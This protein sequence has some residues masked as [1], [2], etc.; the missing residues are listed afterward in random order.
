MLYKN[1]NKFNTTTSELQLAQ[2]ISWV[3]VSSMKIRPPS[4]KSTVISQLRPMSNRRMTRDQKQSLVTQIVFK[5][6]KK[7]GLVTV[8]K[9]I[10]KLTLHFLRNAAWSVSMD[11]RGWSYQFSWLIRTWKL[12]LTSSRV[13]DQDIKDQLALILQHHKVSHLEIISFGKILPSIFKMMSIHLDIPINLP[14][15]P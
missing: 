3:W 10:G 11:I 9:T 15:I 13:K 7:R 8:Y 4:Q 2:I 5:K 14:F 6:R 12:P 1:N